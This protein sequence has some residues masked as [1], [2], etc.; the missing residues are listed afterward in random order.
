M[1]EIEIANEL[2]ALIEQQ[3][4]GIDN[5]ESLRRLKQRAEKQSPVL[6][7]LAYDKAVM[8]SV[9]S[10]VMMLSDKID[11]PDHIEAIRNSLKDSKY[12]VIVVSGDSMIDAG[13]DDGDYCIVEDGKEPMQYNTVITDYRGKIFI[14]RYYNDNESIVLKSANKNFPDIII[15]DNDSFKVLGVVI[16]LIKNI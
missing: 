10:N 3:M 1:N 5:G 14:K 15:E 16:S 13:I 6:Y 7:K 8:K 11:T 9:S 2:A 12:R 4:N